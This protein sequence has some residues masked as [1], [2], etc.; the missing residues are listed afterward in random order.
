MATTTRTTTTT[1]P[2]AFPMSL[3]GHDRRAVTQIVN[4]GIDARLEAFTR[5]TFRDTGHRLEC[6]V[7]PAE[8]SILLRRL[9]ELD[10]GE[11]DESETLA[12][13]IARL[14]YLDDDNED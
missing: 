4:A 11:D 7:H 1:A 6:Q 14:H 13:D 12:E 10:P 9:C 5:S 2:R 8:M 3:V